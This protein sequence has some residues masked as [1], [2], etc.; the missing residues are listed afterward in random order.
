MDI[1]IVKSHMTLIV[2][3]TEDINF[4]NDDV[5]KLE[6]N[7]TEKLPDIIPNSVTHLTFGTMYNQPII[8]PNSIT[9]LTF[10]L[11]YNQPTIIPNSVSHLTFE[12]KYN[13]P[14]II[15][16]SVSKHNLRNNLIKEQN[17]V[18]IDNDD[19]IIVI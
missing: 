8:I 12:W 1:Q 4:L 18:N 3:S 19:D 17:V 15:P 11:V 9:Q 14:T 2:K 6:W 10:G 7:I 13:Q 16:N 5:I